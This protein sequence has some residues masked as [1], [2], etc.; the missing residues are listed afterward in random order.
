MTAESDFV[1]LYPQ[2]LQA[3][4]AKL[5]EEHGTTSGA[6]VLH[7]AS[8]LQMLGLTSTGDGRE[9]ELDASFEGVMTELTRRL[10]RERLGFTDDAVDGCC[11]GDTRT[12]LKS[13][14]GIDLDAVG[15]TPGEQT[16]YYD[17]VANGAFVHELER[18]Y[19]E[20]GDVCF[21]KDGDEGVI[22]GF[23]DDGDVHMAYV[24]DSS[25]WSADEVAEEPFDTDEE[26]DD[27]G[28]SD[29]E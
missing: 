2:F 27:S 20:M 18:E 23:S 25:S 6:A 11:G 13:K 7:Y 19:W 28:T 21:D 22:I 3:M 14:L 15:A 29:P 16:T 1:P 12:A 4:S 8:V 5:V 24:E 17:P 10:Q 9:L 26:D